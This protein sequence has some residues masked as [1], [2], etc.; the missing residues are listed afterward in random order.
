MSEDTPW[1][2]YVKSMDPN[3]PTNAEIRIETGVIEEHPHIHRVFVDGRDVTKQLRGL[4]FTI[5]GGEAA[6]VR[7][8]YARPHVTVEGVANVSTKEA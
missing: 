2:Q 4:D 5:Q 8:T 3:V 6:D 7:I 1:V